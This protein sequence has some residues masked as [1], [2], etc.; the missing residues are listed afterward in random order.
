VITVLNVAGIF[1]YQSPSSERVLG[2]SPAEL[3][4][5][6]VSDFIHP[7]DLSRVREALQRA[8]GLPAIP[9]TVEYRFR[10][11]NGSWRILESIGRSIQG[12]APDGYIIVNSRDIT[13]SMKLE[14][15]LRQSQ[16]MEAIGQLSG[17]VAHDFNNLLTVIQGHVSLLET[18]PTLAAEL[19]ESVTEIR[20]S[21]ERAANLTRQLLAFSRR[22]TMQRTDLDLNEV[23]IHM[24][25]MLK[26]ILGE[27]IQLR[28]NYAPQPVCVHADAGMMEQVLLNLAVNSRDAMPQG[29]QLVLETGSVELD[30]AAAKQMPQARAGA[31]VCLSVSD[32]G[33]G[34]PPEILPHIFE[35]FFT[36]KDVGKGTGLG[37]ATVY[38]IVQQHQ[39]WSSVYSEAGQ[40]TT[41]RIYL[42]RLLK[43]AL[44]EPV[45]STIPS[46]RGG[47]ETI[48]VVE[49]ES[50]LRVLA[51]RILTRLGYRVLEAPTG[52]S[53][54]GVWREH[55]R[56]IQ[57]LLTDLVMPDGMNG[58]DLARHLH[59]DN[60]DLK[61]IYTSGYSAEIA[62]QDFPLVEGLNFLAKP[63]SPSK[64]A[65]IVRASLDR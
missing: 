55:R 3:T 53:A 16:K 15:Q 12:A 24:T 13:E 27:D 20:Q 64:L 33:C 23:V 45:K 46:D 11:R 6:Q 61:V 62:G 58:R 2:Y 21:A 14:E 25:R 17:G 37:L 38:G 1:R 22:Q 41:F 39:G 19:R 40:G 5:R 52:V 10:H 26:R 59:Q 43:A 29:G 50:A 18:E 28:L 47:T 44:A 35:P 36:T 31:F 32:T 57:L 30:E 48:L 34:I 60:P 54:L 42:P 56:E 9:R 49:D 65:H 7:E 4:G 8:A 63:F 51:R